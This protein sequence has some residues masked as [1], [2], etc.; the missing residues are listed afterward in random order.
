MRAHSRLTSCSRRAW[1]KKAIQPSNIHLGK[2]KELWIFL[3]DWYSS[4]Y[5]ETHFSTVSHLFV[6]WARIGERLSRGSAPDWRNDMG[7]RRRS[8]MR[9]EEEPETRKVEHQDDVFPNSIN[10]LIPLPASALSR[11]G[12]QDAVTNSAARSSG[13][14]RL[15]ERLALSRKSSKDLW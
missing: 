8:H 14:K 13:T 5:H 2:R 15:F 7:V 3:C 11:A 1:D 4:K 6:D 12:M 10:V 9:T